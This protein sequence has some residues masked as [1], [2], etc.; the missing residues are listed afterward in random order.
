M[1]NERLLGILMELGLNEKEAKVYLACLSLGPTTVLKIA[2]VTEIKRPSVYPIIERLKQLGLMSE[3]IRGFKTFYRTESPEKL[4]LILEERKA[5]FKNALPDFSQL[6][7][8]QGQHD[9]IK[10]FE[11]LLA[12]KTVYDD[13]LRNIKPHEDYLIIADQEKWLKLDEEFFS[14]FARR[15]A[16]LPINI[17]ALQVDTVTGQWWKKH[18]KNFNT[19][20]KLLPK[21]ISSM[22]TNVVITPQ[23][24]LIH[25]II[26]PVTAL[27]IENKSAIR[28]HQQLFEVI[29]QL[30]P[31]LD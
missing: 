15:R 2:G 25:Q 20:V 14:D 5:K 24:L 22:A 4:E 8:L 30:L 6:Y 26:P 9:V 21:N 19:K 23:T 10:R 11:G 16:K 1:K 7:N 29:W 13:L 17:R 12:V 28:L 27:V 3:E 31:S 18:E